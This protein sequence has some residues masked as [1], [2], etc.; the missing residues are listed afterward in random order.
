MP[1]GGVAG[2]GADRQKGSCMLIL[3]QQYSRVVRDSRRVVLIMF[4]FC[5]PVLG[6]AACSPT[7]LERVD[8]PALEA[9]TVSQCACG[10]QQLRRA[11][12]SGSDPLRSV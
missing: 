5:F 1:A 2:D 8:I 12:L 6:G 7:T 3:R 9:A 10:R 11:V 4:P